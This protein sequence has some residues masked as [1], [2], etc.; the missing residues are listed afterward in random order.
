MP[1]QHI[2]LVPDPQHEA[3]SKHRQVVEN[4]GGTLRHANLHDAEVRRAALAEATVV[5]VQGHTMAEADFAAGPHLRAVCSWSDGV[6]TI[7]LEAAT[8]HGVPVGNV[9][10]LCIDEVAD[11]AL[12]LLLACYRRLGFAYE[13]I[14]KGLP[15]S[16]GA[17]LSAAK[18]WPR[19]RGLTLGLLAFGNIAAA[20]ATRCQALG[21]SV[22]A[23]DPFIDPKKMHDADVE[24]VTFDDL[25]TRSDYLSLHTPLNPRTR[26]VIDAVALEQMKPSAF[27]INTARGPIIDEAALVLTLQTGSIAGAGLDVFEVEPASHDN[28]LFEMPNVITT[29]HH[30]GDSDE[31]W[32]FGPMSVME[33][34]AGVLNGGQPRS[35]QNPA[36]LS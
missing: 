8:Q 18:P 36:V 32:E 27:I 34:V 24:P 25:L 26:H 23:H 35:V 17:I 1:I 21:M 9:P 22:I 3:L 5:V 10:D 2:V 14:H 13:Q 29:P 4:A 19:L 6:D 31:M 20:V 11:H 33:D 30:G 16:R 12:M 15:L 28:P 7:D